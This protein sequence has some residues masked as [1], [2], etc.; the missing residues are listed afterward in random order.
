MASPSPCEV[1]VSFSDT[2]DFHVAFLHVLAVKSQSQQI[3]VL[4]KIL[5]TNKTPVGTML[6]DEY[7]SEGEKDGKTVFKVTANPIWPL[8]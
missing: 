8:K 5:G 4:V 6:E 2:G 1:V 3:W 7:S